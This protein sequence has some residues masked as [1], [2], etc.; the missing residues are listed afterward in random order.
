MNVSSHAEIGVP[1]PLPDS[2]VRR[3][4]KPFRGQCHD[5]YS[6]RAD[7][8][9]EDHHPISRETLRQR[10][11][12]RDKE[13]NDDRIDCRQFPDRCV[14]AELAIAP[15]REDVVHLEENRFEKTNEQEE[16]EQ[17]IETR[18]TD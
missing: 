16:D 2:A 14:K 13:N 3:S 8:A 10:A 12:Y 9:A 4:Q 1:K 11:D 5:E 18:L 7:C 6:S 15:L 17:A